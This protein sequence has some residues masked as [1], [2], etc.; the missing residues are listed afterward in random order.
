M[1]L[2]WRRSCLLFSLVVMGTS[3]SSNP[4]AASAKHH[5]AT[6]T[7][8]NGNGTYSNPLFYEEFSDPDVIRVGTDY[9]LSGTTMHTM[10]GMYV[11][12]SKDLV[13]WDLASYAFDRLDLSPAYRLE[14]GEIYGQGI[15]AP[16]IRYHDG[17]FYLFS[18]VNNSGLHVYRSAS[19]AG[20]WT[21]NLISTRIYDLSVLFD[22]NGKVYAVCGAREISLVELKP[23]LSDVVPNTM[24]VIIQRNQG[25]GEGLHIYKI[26]GKYYIVSAEPGAHTNLL[27]ARAD[28]LEGPWEVTTL[29]DHENL[30]VPSGNLLRTT[31]RGANQTFQLN[32]QNPN[33]GGGLTIHQG[34]IVDTP[35]G[36]WWGIIMSDHN[37]VGRVSDLVP[38]TWDNGWPMVGLPG[39]LRHA[40]E[41]WIKPNTGFAQEPKPLWQRNDSFDSAQM[42]PLW[43][44]N[45]VPVDAKW[46]LTEKPGVLRLHSLPAESFWMAKNTLTQRAVGPEST[47]KVELDA[48]GLKPGDTAGLALLNQPYAWIGLRKTADGLILTQ[49]D[50]TNNKQSEQA[51]TANRVWLAVACNFDTEMAAFS[52]SLDGKKFTGFAEPFVMIFQ[53]KT[54]QG[55]RYSLFNYNTGGAD[56]G[57][58]DFDNFTVDEPRPHGLTQ[59][60]PYGKNI[61]FASLADGSVLTTQ[62]DSL[63]AAAKTDPAAAGPNVRFQVFDRGLGRVALKAG[64]NRF[65][66]VAAD[67]GA[68]SLKAGPPGDSE[69]FQWVDMLTGDVMLMSL[70]NHRFMALKPGSAV[71]AN[72]PGASPDHKNGA[73][74]TW[75][76]SGE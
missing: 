9:Y 49:F 51:V 67:G 70:S 13:N 28:S 8:D 52:Y 42:N 27:C 40:P 62:G 14:G 56:G 60:I 39:N 5:P 26:K 15:W 35:S 19:P 1:K 20:P 22:D 21:H 36:E 3:C 64:D 38:V 68:I 71:L 57:F 54:F 47:V 63:Q 16:C 53:L 59:P 74:L 45:H 23:D 34:G 6:W 25:M 12:H 76:I 72:T 61:S 50:Q 4:P 24:H 11:L 66:S 2:A 30:G 55:I 44:W 46:S 58:A 31:G 65:L 75:K 33:A 18:N 41:L 37:S 43:Q 17:M 29:T 73:G 69:T 7:A 10:P 32:A 48:S